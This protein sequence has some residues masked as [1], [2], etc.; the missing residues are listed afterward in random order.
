MHERRPRAAV[1]TK[2]HQR[3]T[4]T[5]SI[6]VPVANQPPDLTSGRFRK[7]KIAKVGINSEYSRNLPL[8]FVAAFSHRHPRRLVVRMGT[9]PANMKTTSFSPAA[10]KV[11][12][13]R[14]PDRLTEGEVE[15][16][17]TAWTANARTIA[18]LERQAKRDGYKSVFEYLNV[19][20]TSM[21]LSDEETTLLAD[22][23]RIMHE[24]FGW[25]GSYPKDV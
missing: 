3:G 2:L 8:S 18:A 14:L 15:F 6:P 9:P 12:W 16:S 25:D 7:S 24:G 21:L 10:K 4:N 1:S 22:D 11:N 13:S 23:G 5:G 17:I 19:T 20:I